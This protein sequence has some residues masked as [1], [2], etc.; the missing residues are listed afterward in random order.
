MSM[1]LSALQSRSKSD[2]YP[3]AV[4]M[5]NGTRQFRCSKCKHADDAW[6]PG[7]RNKQ[8]KFM[9]K[10]TRHINR[11]YFENGRLKSVAHLPGEPVFFAFPAAL[12]KTA[13]LLS[14]IPKSWRRKI[15]PKLAAFVIISIRMAVC[16]ARRLCKIFKGDFFFRNANRRVLH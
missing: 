16:Q 15:M 4:Q 2:A 13:A 11:Y 5:A 6:K 8:M 3:A 14:N 12:M 1:R 10:L 9:R 7:V